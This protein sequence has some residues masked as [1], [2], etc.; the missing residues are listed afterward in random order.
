MN[1]T[2]RPCVRRIYATET[3]EIPPKGQLDISVKS[4]WS[5]LPPRHVD[6]LVEPTKCGDNVLLARTLLSTEQPQTFVQV[7]NYGP[8]AST[9]AAGDLLGLAEPVEQ[10]DVVVTGESGEQDSS[11]ARPL[12]QMTTKGATVRME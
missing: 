5:S 12:H 10:A 9:I 2:K 8:A 4:V 3:C 11:Q 6:W 7:L 1:A